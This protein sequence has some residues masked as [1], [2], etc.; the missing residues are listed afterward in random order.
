VY[1]ECILC[2]KYAYD[3]CILYIYLILCFGVLENILDLKGGSEGSI[4]QCA[5]VIQQSSGCA[6]PN[7]EKGGVFEHS[8][9]Y[10]LLWIDLRKYFK[11]M[12]AQKQDAQ[13]CKNKMLNCAKA[14]CV[15]AQRKMRVRTKIEEGV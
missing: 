12:I 1:A 8:T 2:L 9:Q 15:L 11:C 4:V 5:G 6:F 3:L 7:V 14:K 10:A 13:L